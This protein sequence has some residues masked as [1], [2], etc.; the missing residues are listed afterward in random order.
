MKIHTT[1]YFKTFIQ[2]A[3]DCKVNEAKIPEIK[4]DN[5]TI[6]SIQYEQLIKNE[7]VFTSDEILFNTFAQKNELLPSELNEARA[8]FFSKGQ[9]CMRCSPLTKTHGFGIHFNEVGKMA[10]IAK[11]SKE[12]ETLLNDEHLKQI[13]AMKSSK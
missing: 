3:E 9:A 1:N 2:V 8:H 4:G 10:L 7:Y 12:Y 11:G 6:A 5:K 13:K